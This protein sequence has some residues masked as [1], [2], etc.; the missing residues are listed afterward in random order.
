MKRHFSTFMVTMLALAAMAVPAKKGLWQTVRL[1]DGSEVRAQLMGDEHLHF[2]QT[3][4]GL[5]LVGGE[6]GTYVKADMDRLRL[7]AAK[8]RKQPLTAGPRR[9]PLRVSIGEQTHYTGRKKG[10]VILMQFTDTKFK[11]A[12]N[13]AKYNNLLNAPDYSEGSFKGSVADYF[14]AQSGGRFE[15]E[16]DVVG[17]FMAAKNTSYYGSNDSDGLDKHPDELI[18]E[19]VKAANA[20]VDFKDYD[21][22]GDGQVDQ[23]FVVYAGKG[24]A[25]GGANTTIWPHMYWLS[26]TN[27]SLTLDGVRI[28]T[29]ACSN[30]IDP[31]GSIEGIGCFCHEFSHCLGYPDFYDTSY[32]GWFGM[33]AWDLMDQG[34]YNGNGFRPAGYSAY[35]KWMAGWLEPVELDK[36]G[37]TIDSLRAISEG[38]GAYII[39]NDGHRDEYYMVENRQKTGW[40]ASLPGKGLMITHVDFDKAIWEDNTPNTRV[41]TSDMYENGYSKTNDHQRFTIFHADN[42]AS[43]GNM[44]TDLYPYGSKDSLTDTST[45]K[46]SLYNANTDGSKLM[47]KPI[48]GIKQNSDQ[49]IS[50][51]FRG[52]YVAP[53]TTQVEPSDTTAVEPA[54][55][56]EVKPVDP[57]I[58]ITGDTLFYES[59]NQCS[60]KGGNDGNWSTQGNFSGSS[61]YKPDNSAWVVNNNRAYGGYEC[62]RFG[63][64]SD[65]GLLTSPT[66]NVDGE[67]TLVFRAAGWYK[68]DM[69]LKVNIATD[70][71]ELADT[72]L[73]MASF[74]WTDFTVHFEGKGHAHIT[75]RPNRRFILDDVLVVRG[76]QEQPALEGDLNADGIVDLA[77]VATAISLIAAAPEAE[78]P[79]LNA[80]GQFDIADILC[81]LNKLRPNTGGE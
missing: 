23:V 15:L 42:T 54:D 12:N 1:A 14:R 35:E 4:S 31:Y 59:F 70:Y 19:A 8:R 9:A 63:T 13:K 6:D 7:N 43:I 75:F 11:T 38:G 40:D 26:A 2:W 33:G 16:F 20:E 80:D 78:R 49:T 36:E 37:A 46:A 76:R 56:V 57:V 58:V 67:A 41:T 24:E 28:D 52:G 71:A 27:K 25:D 47:H 17:P 51:L 61:T 3:E 21:W 44:S 34:S 64:G 29:Y 55:T 30:E 10:V 66:F 79:D 68:D 77:D 39:Y 53:D 32:S 45:P 73:T 81:L 5:K 72:T 62:A 74:A 69:S 50:F 18:V 48:T 65:V 22:D 60:G